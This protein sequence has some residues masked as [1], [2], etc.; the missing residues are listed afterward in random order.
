MKLLRG[1]LS[2]FLFLFLLTG[3][4]GLSVTPSEAAQ[5]DCA[6]PLTDGDNPTASDCLNILRLAVGIA[7]VTCGPCDAA[8]CQPNGGP[9]TTATDALRCLRTAVG[10]GGTLSCP[11]GAPEGEL[12]GFEW[13]F[14]D[15]AKIVFGPVQYDVPL[16]PHAVLQFDVLSRCESG[17]QICSSDA[18]C[19]AADPC[20][21]TC[22]GTGECEVLPNPALNRCAENMNVVCSSDEDCPEADTCLRYFAT[23][24]PVYHPAPICAIASVSDIQPGT[25]NVDTGETDIPLNLQFRVWLGAELDSCP[26]CGSMVEDL[27][28]GDTSTC[29]GGIRDGMPCTVQGKYPGIAT[30]SF[31]CP[32]TPTAN[33]T[34]S[35][36]PI[37]LN[38][39]TGSI[40]KV[41]NLSCRGSLDTTTRGFC[42][43]GQGIV[44]GNPSC[45]TNAD[46][47]RCSDD[48]AVPCASNSD[49]GAE[50]LAAPDQPI[51][52]GLYCHCGTCSQDHT[53]PC[54]SDEEC[55]GENFCDTSRTQP[56][57]NATVPNVCSDSICGVTGPGECSESTTPQNVCSL[58]TEFECPNE[59]TCT[60]FGFGSCDTVTQGFR[61]FEN[62]I[63][64]SGEAS[65]GSSIEPV[66]VG[67][68]CSG[69][70]TVTS[71]AG[72]F[73]QVAQTPGPVTADMPSVFTKC[74][75]GN[76]TVEC[77]EQCDDGVDGSAACNTDCTAIP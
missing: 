45:S 69:A 27:A 3:L 71:G 9:N 72:L 55:G 62:R 33:I 39:T 20:T 37:P 66:L 7:G 5:C 21:P 51:T 70:S 47:M 61:C 1:A 2:A 65:G 64:V 35:G 30:T 76:S 18:D 53:I 54:A 60:Q 10:A 50:C 23:P 68:T 73:D 43:D 25:I 11:T 15:G 6:Q 34:G 44:D 56:E 16:S 17:G 38:L 8:V 19:A 75:C 29:L 24:I 63:T 26:F 28:I 32:P 12:T 52:C 42:V 40:E 49:C 74:I 48:L 31:D 41:A 67:L 57:R 13:S 4:V 77:D 36:I 58:N 14:K 22:D 59:E 46:C